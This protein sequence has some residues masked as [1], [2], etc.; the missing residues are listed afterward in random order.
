MPII[1]PNMLLDW[2]IEKLYIPNQDFVPCT[3]EI[4]CFT[5]RSLV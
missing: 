1:D 4:T 2:F 3:G 5:H